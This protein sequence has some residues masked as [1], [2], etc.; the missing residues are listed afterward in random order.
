MTVVVG[1]SFALLPGWLNEFAAQL[2]R[3]PS[4]TAIGSPVWII[5][6][7]YLPWLGAPFEVGMTAL[8]VLYLLFEWRRLPGSAAAS[9]SFH[10]RHREPSALV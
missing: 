10:W 1:A 9:A 2:G 5:T 8:L 3:Y 6:Q 7:Y 4:Y